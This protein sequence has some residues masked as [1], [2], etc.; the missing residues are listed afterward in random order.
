MLLPEHSMHFT[1]GF[2][3]AIVSCAKYLLHMWQP[4]ETDCCLLL[5]HSPYI[6]FQ[7]PIVTFHA[8]PTTSLVRNASRILTDIFWYAKYKNNPFYYWFKNLQFKSA[9]TKNDWK[10]DYQSFCPQLRSKIHVHSSKSN[11]KP[12][13]SLHI[14]HERQVLGKQC[15]IQGF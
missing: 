12:A 5:I 3:P 11:M 1:L 15:F 14:L 10:N 13:G 2:I 9:S 7:N 6:A 4:S 8:R